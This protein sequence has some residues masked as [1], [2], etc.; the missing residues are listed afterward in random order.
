MTAG[1]AGLED[2]GAVVQTALEG[3]VLDGLLAVER[4]EDPAGGVGAGVNDDGP[5]ELVGAEFPAVG[6]VAVG[7]VG[8]CKT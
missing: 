6:V 7:A 4:A 2:E 1:R 5:V 3:R 8:A